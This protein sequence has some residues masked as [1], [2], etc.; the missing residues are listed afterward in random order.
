MNSVLYEQYYVT[1]FCVEEVAYFIFV[2]RLTSYAF[3]LPITA[4]RD[5]TL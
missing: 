4:A 3:L 5:H 1:N 2:L